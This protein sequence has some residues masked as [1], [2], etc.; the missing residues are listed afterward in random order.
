M[1]AVD[2]AKVTTMSTE[3][4]KGYRKKLAELFSG[5]RAEWIEEDIF[6]LFTEPSY[7]PQLTTSHPCF[8]IGGRGTGKTTALRCMSYQ[9]QAALGGAD[10]Q[11]V[12]DWPYF[13]MYHRINTNR[14]R[15][16]DGP[17]LQPTDWTR[18]FGHYI[19]L[20]FCE[21]LLGFLDWYALRHKDASTLSMGSLKL[22]ATALHLEI[23][24]TAAELGER[25]ELSKLQFEAAINNVAGGMPMPPISLQGAPI[26][27]LV[28]EIKRLPQFSNKSFFFLI[29]EY[30]N[31]SP[32]QQRV[33]NTLIKH[34]GGLYS[35]KVG[36]RELG[37]RDRSTLNERE[38]LRSPADYRLIDIAAE[39]QGRFEEFA[40]AVC[41]RRLRRIVD[42]VGVQPAVSVLLP[43][44]SAEEEARNLGVEAAVLAALREM[45]QNAV[46][47]DRFRTWAAEVEPLE[48]FVLLSRARAEG[49][50]VA[51]KLSD[52]LANPPKWTEQYGNYKHALLF[53]IRR[54]KRGIRKHFA[55]WRVF[56]LLAA[57]NV[58]FLLE[59]VD[60]ALE[61]HLDSGRDLLEPVPVDVQTRAA[62][63]TG[64]RNLRELEGLSLSGAKLMRLLLGL[65]RVFQVMAEDPVGHTPEV[66]QFHLSANVGDS[67]L[68]ERVEVLLAEGI[69]HLALL[70][71]PG[72][73]L[74]NE[75]DIRQ[76][77][78][79]VHPIFSAVFGFSHRRKRKIELSDRDLCELVDR[80]TEAIREIIGR[81]NRGID[82]SLPEQ[83]ELFANFYV[84][85]H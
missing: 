12:S 43:G 1:G 80:P 21:S 42:T 66:N 46:C 7:F 52:V 69:M 4:I 57:S 81:Q 45:G 70:R 49:R 83:M 75:T 11:H 64:Q 32:R 85:S 40:S 65:G 33:V 55:G 34:C 51:D 25:L 41:D 48:V 18:L 79:A 8:L 20:E 10:Q 28:R 22:I 63:E 36:V 68:R 62:Q 50:T 67:G 56:C 26:D 35:F 71:Y 19:N 47:G 5:Y 29:D 24:T 17:E 9:G 61:R 58:R 14:V 59:L 72:S 30:E 76:F 13:G 54:G 77:D 44:V 38:Q 31:L 84:P 3:T 23:P 16:F 6:D 73:K 37:L 39:L 2:S 78:Y 15:A 60:Q 74:Q 27:L 82:E 53:A